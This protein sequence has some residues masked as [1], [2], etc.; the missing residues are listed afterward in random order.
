MNEFRIQTEFI[1]VP[2]LRDLSVGAYCALLA[3]AR[4]VR[5]LFRRCLGFRR[6]NRLWKEAVISLTVTRLE[7]KS[8]NE[9]G[10]ADERATKLGR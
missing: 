3:L 1:T 4:L 5:R 10:L 9:N 6:R 7:E 2:P 8:E